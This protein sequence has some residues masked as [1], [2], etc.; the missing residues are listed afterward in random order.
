M[1]LWWYGGNRQTVGIAREGE[2]LSSSR[3]EQKSAV[4]N[5]IGKAFIGIVALTIQVVCI[6]LMAQ[7]L[8]AW[9]TVITALVDVA[10]V[11][12]V[13]F[14]YG[15]RANAAYKMPWIILILAFPLLGVVLYL[16]LGSHL[17][18]SGVRRQFA[19]MER[20]YAGSLV[21]D[22]E[23]FKA[24][25]EQNLA[26]ANQFRYVRDFG[27]Y[28]VWR[29]C[30]V[31]YYGD[32]SKA[33]DAQIEE[34]KRAER[35]IFMEYFAIEDKEAFSRVLE[36]LAERAAAGVEVR[37]FYDDV[38]SVGFINH[39][40]LDKVRGLGIQCRVFNAVTPALMIFVNNRDHRKMTIIDG[41]A[42]FTGGYNLANEYFNITSPYG[43][44][45]DAGVRVKG[46]AV[47]NFTEMFLQ[48]WD[49]MRETD[50]SIDR[51]LTQYPYEPEEQ[52]GFVAPFADSPL[53]DESTGEN[54]YMNE[55]KCAERYA[56]FMTP[57]L[58]LTDEF[59]REL[60]TAAKRGVD[61]RIIT[62]GIPDKRLVYAATRSYYQQLVAGGVRIYEYTPGFC[63]SKLS[64]IDGET[65]TVGTINL[66]MRS[67]YLHFEDGVLLYD[68]Q[69]V[70]D[71]KADLDETLP[72]CREVTDKYRTAHWYVN[73]YR[74]VLRLIAPLL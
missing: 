30:D 38:G 41:K 67:L 25:E 60:R 56:W 43:H 6:Y 28:P 73:F 3:S 13:L 23:A 57:Y 72:Q 49:S 70:A 34:L 71:V 58:I 19:A 27:R 15:Q 8:S 18:T 74:A 40:F 36:V 32:A 26:I 22:E 2:P 65:A 47:R 21:Q 12:L 11:L 45:K 9:S 62:P 52:R 16:L 68:C 29:G 4:K 33:L 1:P 69:A 17:T 54:V 46:P 10:A 64:V 51:Y 61:V 48:M 37:M 59:S 31:T 20:K 14:L 7:W 53:D 39:K 55:L 35:F 42:A 63:H 5:N 24:L 50:V 44:W 66:D